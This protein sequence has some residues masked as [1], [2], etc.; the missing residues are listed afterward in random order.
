MTQ[1][2]IKINNDRN[3]GNWNLTLKGVTSAH[4]KN[5]AITL[6]VKEIMLFAFHNYMM[7]H[8]VSAQYDNSNNQWKIETFL[9]Q[10]L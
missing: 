4:D 6:F 5:K 3:G 7:F 10:R 2:P 8:L 9:P 1:T